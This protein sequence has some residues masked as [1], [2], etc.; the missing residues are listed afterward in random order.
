MAVQPAPHP[1]APLPGR[2]S[3]SCFGRPLACA[4]TGCTWS[5]PWPSARPA[6]CRSTPSSP[7]CPRRPSRAA[8]AT[9]SGPGWPS[10]DLKVDLALRMDALSGLLCLVITFIGTL[11][12]IY[13][14]GYMAHDKD[15]ARFFAYLNLFCGAML[16]LVLGDCLPVMFIG[17]EGVG[18]CSYLLIGFW[19][20][21]KANAD[22]GKKAFITNRVGDFGF[23]IG[24]FLLFQATG[25]LDIP[26]DHRRRPRT[27]A[28]PCTQPL[29]AGPAGRLLGGAVPVRRRRR[30][31]GADPALRLAARRHGRP[32][33]G[34]GA[35][36]RRHHGHRRRV[37]GGPPAAR[38]TCSPRPPWPSWPWWA[39]PPRCSRPS[40]ASPR[41]TSRRCW[42]T[43]RSASSA[44]CSRA[45]GPGPSTPGSSTSTP[46]PSS[47][48][49]CSSAPAR[50][51][52]P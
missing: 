17:W 26:A 25:T 46:T 23:L 33:A 16:V 35:D 24:M 42:P 6:W 38:S 21:E 47:R 41:T 1:A 52:T 43:P 9:W 45:W 28:G 2:G 19:Y 31:V 8:C 5:P 4:G 29:L 34:L 3:C 27:P 36:P 40:S 50:S 10:G 20:E 48:P 22:A 15:Y 7:T 44:S 39:R 11:I 49:A 13:S 37:H 32:H 18:L 12:H 30:Q 14:T 51:C